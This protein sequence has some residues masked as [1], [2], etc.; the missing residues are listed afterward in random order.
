[1]LSSGRSPVVRAVLTCGFGL[2]L[3]LALGSAD[4]A[5]VC[6]GASVRASSAAGPARTRHPIVLVHGLFGFSRLGPMAYFK[7]VAVEL[8]RQGAVV[9]TAALPPAQSDEVRGRRLLAQLSCWQQRDGHTRFN[10]IGHSQ[11]GTTGRYAAALRPDL[12]ASVTT[13]GTPHFGSAVADLLQRQTESA[14]TQDAAAALANAFAKLLALLSEAPVGLEDARAALLSLS[15]QGAA[16]FNALYPLGA[17]P[18]PCQ[19]G[20]EEQGGVH[21]YSFGGTAAATVAASDLLL[22]PFAKA[23]G[24]EPNDGLVGLC[25][26]YWGLPRRHDLKLNHLDQVNHRHLGL[27]GS[28]EPLALY[29]EHAEFLARRGL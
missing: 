4:A 23:F 29:R 18:A 21:F 6:E 1:M 28:P 2:G 12:V 27:F 10:L 16:R 13:V 9:Y 22:R 8:S 17:P 5:P 7:D 19:A 15:S 25:A 20:P 14:G 24:A 26:S 11:G 3:W